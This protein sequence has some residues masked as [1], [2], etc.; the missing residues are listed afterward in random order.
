VADKIRPYLISA[1]NASGQTCTLH[2][3]DRYVVHDSQDGH[4]EKLVSSLIRTANGDILQPEETE[5]GKGKFR[6]ALSGEVFTLPELNS[7]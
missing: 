6:A 1:T 5:L 3:E 4:V 7:P 2:V